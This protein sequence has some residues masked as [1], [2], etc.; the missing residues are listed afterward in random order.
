M[1][2]IVAKSLGHLLAGFKSL[3]RG[4]RSDIEAVRASPPLPE[5]TD[6]PWSARGVAERYHPPRA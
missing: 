1:E 5:T 3:F 6:E 2:R 4:A